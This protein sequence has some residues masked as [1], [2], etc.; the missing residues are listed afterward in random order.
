M[1]NFRPHKATSFRF[2]QLTRQ[3]RKSPSYLMLLLLLWS[4]DK[5]GVVVCLV[6]K[7]ISSHLI[8]FHYQSFLLVSCR[9]RCYA[10]VSVHRQAQNSKAQHSMAQHSIIYSQLSLASANCLRQTAETSDYLS[11]HLISSHLV[12][13]FHLICS[14]GVT[15]VRIL[16]L[17]R[18]QTTNRKFNLHSP[19]A[20][21][22]PKAGQQ[23]SEKPILARLGS[24][25]VGRRTGK[26][27]QTYRARKSRLITDDARQA[28]DWLDPRHTYIAFV[29]VAVSLAGLGLCRSN[30][31]ASDDI[32]TAFI[33]RL[34]MS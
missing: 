20:K 16:R 15:S 27:V 24:S 4:A 10:L 22:G 19:A 12:A 21:F 18:G 17:V 6:V 1:S 26:Q 23:A 34:F 32:T 2:E 14:Y 33:F 31:V 3:N 9:F 7:I 8:W 5:G 13:S 30:A 28:F 29:G 11:S 25:R